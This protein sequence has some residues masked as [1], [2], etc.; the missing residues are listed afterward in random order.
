MI[1]HML[2]FFCIFLFNAN[3]EDRPNNDIP[4]QTLNN[5]QNMTSFAKNALITNT[6]L[7][8]QEF[9]MNDTDAPTNTKVEDQYKTNAYRDIFFTTD[10]SASISQA[11]E[12][13]K[14]GKKMFP[15]DVIKQ[16]QKVEKVR[17]PLIKLSSIMYNTKDSWV[18][19]TSIGKFNSKNASVAGIDLTGISKD[20]A[21]FTIPMDSFDSKP[22]QQER[23]T[24]QNQNVIVTLRTGECIFEEELE[25]TKNC[26]VIT[27]MVDNTVEVQ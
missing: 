15:S 18:V 23:V 10:E 1:L 4:Q 11:L 14:Q 13:Y 24:I 9:G 7:A 27:E 26:R 20:E 8:R 16:T 19:F 17:K 2:L 5:L 21:E 3:A 12:Y 6:N 22:E 25:I